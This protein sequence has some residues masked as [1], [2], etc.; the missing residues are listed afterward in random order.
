MLSA[1][2]TFDFRILSQPNDVKLS[3][4][5]KLMLFKQFVCTALLIHSQLLTYA[6]R[7]VNDF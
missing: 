5:M 3:K 4:H 1:T 6:I 7:I 2:G